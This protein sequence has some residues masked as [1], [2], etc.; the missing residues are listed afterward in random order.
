MPNFCEFRNGEDECSD[1]APIK[2]RGKWYCSFHYDQL[3]VEDGDALAS[4]LGGLGWYGTENENS[5]N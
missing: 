2:H 4:W 3:M 1:P 5:R